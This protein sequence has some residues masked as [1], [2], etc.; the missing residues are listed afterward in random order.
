MGKIF[1][2][3]EK[4]CPEKK[5][6]IPHLA[7][8]PRWGI[9]SWLLLGLT[10]RGPVDNRNALYSVDLVGHRLIFVSTQLLL[11]ED[12]VCSVGQIGS[13]LCH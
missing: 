5:L 13:A 1:P 7:I 6:K 8:F 3:E 10:L 11:S 4:T 12:V 2:L 9:Q